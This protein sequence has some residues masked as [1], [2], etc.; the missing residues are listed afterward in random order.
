MAAAFAVDVVVVSYNSRDTLRSCV[1]RLADMP[2]VSVTVVDNASPDGSLEVIAGLD[3]RTIQSGRNGGFSFGCN[4]GAAAGDR[5]Y[6][7]FLNPDAEIS[8]QDLQRMAAVLEAEAGV[9]LVGPKL[10]DDDG[11]PMPS[12]RRF[13]SASALWAQAVFLHRLLPSAAWA[14]EIE[15]RSAVYAVPGDV[16]WVSGACM[17]V[18]RTVLEAIG[19]LDEGFFLYC[20]DMDLCARVRAAGYA[21][22]YEPAAAARHTGGHSAPRSGLLAVLA[23]SR[24]RYAQVHARGTV[25]AAHRVGVA[26]DALTHLLFTAATGRRDESRGHRRA[27]AAALRPGRAAARMPHTAPPSLER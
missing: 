11:V 23:V 26:L 17:L 16:D 3:V 4:L 2:G 14:N 19:G 12:I 7:L 13:Q 21:V 6:V 8:A 10:V 22:R 25:A 1:Q 15:R 20:E 24:I 27:L 18:R 5:P 9:G